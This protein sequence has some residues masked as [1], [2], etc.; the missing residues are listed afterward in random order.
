MKAKPKQHTMVEA[1]L[2]FCDAVTHLAQGVSGISRELHRYNDAQQKPENRSKMS[3][4][5]T[6]SFDQTDPQTRSLRA[7]E[8]ERERIGN[9]GATQASANRRS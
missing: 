8:V 1:I 5:G 2:F 9:R 3:T 6:A 7:L 4:W